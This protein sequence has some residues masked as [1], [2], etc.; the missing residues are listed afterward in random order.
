MPITCI[1][2]L[3]DGTPGR[4][5][6]WREIDIPERLYPVVNA[7]Y[8]AQR[9]AER[10][11][12]ELRCGDCTIEVRGLPGGPERFRVACEVVRQY[13]AEKVESTG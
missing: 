5:V 10:L 1:E 13:R 2:I 3:P 11:D 7:E 4:S 6:E 9:A 12:G 8:L